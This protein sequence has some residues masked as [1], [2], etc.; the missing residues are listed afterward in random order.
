MALS[1]AKKGKSTPKADDQDEGQKS[2]NQSPKSSAKSM[3]GKSSESSGTAWM[4]RGKAAKQALVEEEARAEKAKEEAGK[5]WRFWMPPDEERKITFLDGD[6]DDDG[7]LDIPMF[8]EH[9]VKVNGQWENYVCTQESEGFCPICAKGDNKPT[10]VGVMTIIDHTPHKIKSGPNAGKTIQHTRKLFVAKKQTI[11]N[12]AK[13]AVKRGGLRGCT[14]DVM[15]G[16]DKTASVGSQFDFDTKS[17]LEEIAKACGLKM[18]EVVPADYDKEITYRSVEEL[19]DLGLGS[20]PSGP[21]YGSGNSAG[22]SA[23]SKKN[24]GDEL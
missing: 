3:S 16:D 22:N 8:H 13:L 10:L 9:S 14:F 18:E 20:G 1:F 6:L 5:M 11:R 12:L 19:V 7:M 15:R 2:D 24:L 4:K 17:T 21:G 23:A